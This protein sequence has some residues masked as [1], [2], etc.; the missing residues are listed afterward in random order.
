MP[1]AG[2]SWTCW[3]VQCSRERTSL[4][5]VETDCN[6]SQMTSNI[7]YYPVLIILLYY[8]YM[9]VWQHG[10]FLSPESIGKN[11]ETELSV[12]LCTLQLQHSAV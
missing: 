11:F 4:G 6:C 10:L 7:I 9:F 12:P 5:E 3:R 8:I 1:L 2:E